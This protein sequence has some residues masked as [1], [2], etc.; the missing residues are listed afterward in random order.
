VRL[1]RGTPDAAGH[2]PVT[3]TRRAHAASAFKPARPELSIDVALGPARS[4]IEGL[5]NA[6]LLIDTDKLTIVAA[7]APASALLGVDGSTLRS[8]Y[9]MDLAATPEDA[10]F[11]QEAAQGVREGLE[12]QTWVRRADGQLVPV[13]RRITHLRLSAERSLFMVVLHDR[14]QELH[15]ETELADRISELTATLE[16]THDGILVT[17]LGGRIRNFNRRF[18]ALWDVPESL[19]AQPDPA[20]ILGWMQQRVEEPAAYLRR[21]ATLDGKPQTQ[22]TDVIHLSGGRVLERASQPQR[23]RD[24]VVGRVYSF[25]DISER[26]EANRRIDLL[27]H[28]DALTGL[29]NRRALVNRIEHAVAMSQRTGTPFALLFLNLDRFKHINDTLGRSLGDRVLTDVAERLLTTLR[30]VDTVCRTGADEF[31]L[32][33]QH[34]DAAGAQRSAQRVLEV[35]QRS[36][37][38]DDLSFTVTC[39]LGVA[40]YPGDGNSADELLQAADA[41]MHEAKAAGGSGMR[42]YQARDPSSAKLRN[43]MKLDHAMRQ[44]LVAGRFRLHYQPQVDL[45]S[46]EIL[47]AEALI[48]WRDPELGDVTPGEFIPVAERSGFIVALG[49]W[50]L[51]QAV[52]QAALWRDKGYRLM[53]S[54]NVSALQFQQPDFVDSVARVLAEAGLEPQWLEL[55]LTESILIQDAQEALNRLEGLAKLGVRLAI[56]DFGTGYSSLAY[57]KRFPIGRLKIDRS[58]VKGLPADESDAGIVKAIANMAR[59]LHLTLIAEGVETEAQRQFMKELGCQQFQGFLKSPAVD[60]VSFESVMASGEA[61]SA[62]PRAKAK[63]IGATTPEA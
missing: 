22:A 7:N 27:S 43:R 47:G 50:V 10:A 39:S 62:K 23:S 24:Q 25:R 8:W 61:R 51:Q 37:M 31:V 29:P 15:A 48:R 34:A 5:L 53:M 41:A 59:A 18:A 42:S 9:A 32:L 56:D 11:W 38:L 40:L 16:S 6:V 45:L 19:L 1:L 58:F 52:H 63:S 35:M 17:D 12:S 49:A 28:T 33:V 36:F 30:E 54:V 44:A 2:L 60:V 46:G 3:A 21:L 26:V 13:H 20:A 55:E 4:L 57:L 14:S